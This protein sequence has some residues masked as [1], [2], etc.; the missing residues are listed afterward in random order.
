M[1]E[2]LDGC[3]AECGSHVCSL[4]QIKF[5]HRNS[6]NCNQQKRTFIRLWNLHMEWTWFVN[7]FTWKTL[8]QA[9]WVPRMKAYDCNF[10]TSQLYSLLRQEISRLFAS[11]LVYWCFVWI[12]EQTAIISLYSIKWLVF[13][14]EINSLSSVVT[15]YTTRFTFTNSAFC[16]H[17]VFM[18]FV[19]IS[20]Q[21]AVI[22]LYSINWLVLLPRRS[23]FCA[24]RTER[25]NIIQVNQSCRKWFL[26]R[27]ANL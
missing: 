5:R 2:T 20:E 15:I 8:A 25:L 13:I 27:L 16:P 24:V 1:K 14:R 10:C 3:G 7:I 23:V 21:T 6:S 19:R 17:S 9:V 18:C 26:C 22:S 11:R 12:S 4:W